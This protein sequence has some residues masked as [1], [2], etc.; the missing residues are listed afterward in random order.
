[1]AVVDPTI[2]PVE[3]FLYN[4]K[5][6][7]CE[8]FA[9]A[10]TLML[11][12]AG[13]PARLI[14][15]FKGGDWNELAQVFSVR[16]KHAHSWVEALI[17]Q[18]EGPRPRPIWRPLDPT[19]ARQREASVASVS[20]IA[21]RFR[22]A[23]D[24]FRYLWVFYV[25]GFDADRQQRLIYGP[26]KALFSEARRG[27]VLM[28]QAIRHSLIWLLDFPNTQSLFSA[29]G[30]LA[31]AL[32][33]ALGFLA[34]AVLFRL[35]RWLARRLKPGGDDTADLGTG[36]AIYRRLVQLLAE[37]GLSRPSAETPREFARR[38]AE[39]LG[40]QGNELAGVPLFIVEAFYRV[41]FG[42]HSLAPAELHDLEAHLD[43]LEA[44]LKPA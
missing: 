35:T 9:S 40:S 30:L 12:T 17:G 28:G 31:I 14:N 4:R 22:F 25:V 32:V 43:A 2:D 3:D 21:A 23:T 16:Q 15:G 8:Y 10:L 29:R 19:P 26:I 13:I 42:H 44:A 38:A 37:A 1:M 36:V 34:L 5:E 24:Y 7:H 27:F 6:G 18:T 33:L 39:T 41:R 20:G 11:R